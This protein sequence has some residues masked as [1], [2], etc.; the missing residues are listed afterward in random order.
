MLYGYLVLGSVIFIPFA[1]TTPY[2]AIEAA[3]VSPIDII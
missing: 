2:E 3:N 1:M